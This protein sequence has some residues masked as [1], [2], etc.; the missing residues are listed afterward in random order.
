[1]QGTT[2]CSSIDAISSLD[3]DEFISKPWY[4]VKQRN[5]VEVAGA[6][7]STCV[8]AQYSL[9]VGLRCSL[10]GWQVR[11]NNFAVDGNGDNVGVTLCAKIV[12]EAKLFVAPCFLPSFISFFFGGSNYWIIDYNETIGYVV[13]SGGQPSINTGNGCI[14]EDSDGFW[15]LARNGTN[16]TEAIDAAEA[17]ALEAGFNLDTLT[18]Y[19]TVNQTDCPTRPF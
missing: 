6:D 5:A 16:S 15:I 8:E 12:S 9:D 13:V 4:S 10:F 7:D 3:I 19:E 14:N 18:D 1:M 2:D 11:V 17:A